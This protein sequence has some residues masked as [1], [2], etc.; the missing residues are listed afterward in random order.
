MPRGS[1]GAQELEPAAASG[2]GS[3]RVRFGPCVPEEALGT[4]DNGSA[5]GAI[6]SS[7]GWLTSRE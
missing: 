5:L 3:A 2:S 1:P 7:G 4:A 6:A